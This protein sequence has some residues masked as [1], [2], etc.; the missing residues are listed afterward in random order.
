MNEKQIKE[1]INEL[2]RNIQILEE[3]MNSKREG[4]GRPKGSLKYTIEQENFLRENKD[5]PMKKLV[6]M[7]NK[8]FNTNYS[9][10][11]RALY[12]FMDREG[13]L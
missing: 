10:E 2:K 9:I 11:T 1:R 6:N 8:K 7:F 5:V 3:V 12:N 4:I 13:F